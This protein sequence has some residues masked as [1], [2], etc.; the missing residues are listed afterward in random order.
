MRTVETDGDARAAGLLQKEVAVGQVGIGYVAGYDAFNV[1]A[2]RYGGQATA[3]Q[4]AHVTDADEVFGIALAAQLIGEHNVTRI[5]EQQLFGGIKHGV[6]CRHR[7]AALGG[8]AG[9]E[10]GEPAGTNHDSLAV[11]AL[12]LAVEATA[13]HRIGKGLPPVEW[14]ELHVRQLHQG[15]HIVV[16]QRTD[17]FFGG[18]HAV[19]LLAGKNRIGEVQHIA[20]AFA[21]VFGGHVAAQL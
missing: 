11:A 17:A 6:Y 9:R 1:L 4:V 21:A 8:Q 15:I 12:Q 13:P 5:A 18:H 20:Q 2:R 10:I 3:I 16:V 7:A 14:G 19:A